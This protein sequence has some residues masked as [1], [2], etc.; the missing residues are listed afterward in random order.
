MT[1]FAVVHTVFFVVLVVLF[2][3]FVRRPCGAS[4]CCRYF[5]YAA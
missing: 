1:Y 2:A 4:L 5:G 3:R